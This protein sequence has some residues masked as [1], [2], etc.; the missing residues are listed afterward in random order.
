VTY[1]KGILGRFLWYAERQSWPDDPRFLNEWHIR[2]FLGYVGGEV[3]RWGIAGNGSE[4]SSR[5]AAPRTIHHYHRALQAFFNWAVREGF[6]AESPVAKVK[7]A[8]PKR[9]VVRPYSSGQIR[10]L[11]S[12]WS[13]V[14]VTP[15]T[16]AS[17]RETSGGSPSCA[18]P[19]PWL[20][21]RCAFFP[22]LASRLSTRVPRRR[23]SQYL[24]GKRYV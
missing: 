4:S 15:G 18:G 9:K 2:E 11:L 1:Y 3:N 19:N 10:D 20:Q 13:W 8:K 6:L 12:S 21:T 14:R 23:T 7:V 24:G 17:Q 5:K 22:P 16:P